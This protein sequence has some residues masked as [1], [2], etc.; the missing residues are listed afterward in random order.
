MPEYTIDVNATSNTSVNTE[1]T[2]V[3]IDGF[4]KVKKVEVRLGD[5]TDT[6]G[7]DNNYK[8][9][10]ITKSVLGAT[11]TGAT[12]VQSKN[13]DDRAAGIAA[14]V[15]NGTTAFSVGTVADVLKVGV[16]NARE[17]F[18]WEPDDGYNTTKDLAD[19]R[20]LGVLIQ[21]PVVSTKFQVTVTYEE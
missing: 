5:G 9:R 11:G 15:K 20:A 2:F 3:E 6:V 7:L 4:H 12:E 21:N 18:I 13:A 8:V 14:L 17:T 19:G 1:D 10:V 16:R